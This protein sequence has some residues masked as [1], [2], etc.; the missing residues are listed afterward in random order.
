M[1]HLALLV[2]L[3]CGSYHVQAQ[4]YV[5]TTD[6]TAK[7]THSIT[8]NVPFIGIIELE[9]ASYAFQQATIPFQIPVVNGYSKRFSYPELD[10]LASTPRLPIKQKRS[11]RD[12]DA[13]DTK[14]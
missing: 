5:I 6:S 2:A 14:G 8:L 4:A 9:T 12:V 10:T 7:I 11:L 13:L 1:K 3:L